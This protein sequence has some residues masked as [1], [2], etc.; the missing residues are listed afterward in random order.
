MIQASG[1]RRPFEPPFAVKNTTDNRRQ[2]TD[3]RPQ[4]RTMMYPHYLSMKTTL[5]FLTFATVTGLI[6]IPSLTPENYLELTEGKTVFIRFFA[7]Y[8]CT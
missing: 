7:T 4:Q 8:V 3:N 1:R 5:L 2:T 6:D